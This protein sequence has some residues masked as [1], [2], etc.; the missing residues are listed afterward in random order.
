MAVLVGDSVTVTYF[1]NLFIYLFIIYS[2]A[3]PYKVHWS[4]TFTGSDISF[5]LCFK[6]DLMSWDLGALAVSLSAQCQCSS[7][8]GSYY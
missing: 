8:Y 7:G 1:L 2:R 5:G 4:V 6:L 3:G